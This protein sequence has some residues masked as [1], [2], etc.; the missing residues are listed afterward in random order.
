MFKTTIG[1]LWNI[2][3]SILFY[4]GLWLIMAIVCPKILIGIILTYIVS[5]F[6]VKWWVQENETCPP[7][8]KAGCW[9]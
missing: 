3:F 5:L 2:V 4:T 1:N 6:F 7:P 8:F 9:V